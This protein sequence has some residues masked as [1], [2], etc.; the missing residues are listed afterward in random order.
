M[1]RL[2]LNR[3]LW[4]AVL[5]LIVSAIVF[6][7]VSLTPGSVAAEILGP[8]AATP[9]NVAALNAKLGLDQPFYVQY[10]MWLR[11]AVQGDLGTSLFTGEPVATMLNGRI[12]ATVSLMAVTT[13]VVAVIGVFLGVVS[14]LRKGGGGA[15]IDV[16]S[17]LAYSLPDF[18]MAL[19]LVATFSVGLGLL[20]SFG[21]TPF[22]EDPSQWAYFL[23]L[24]VAA[25][26]LNGVARIAKQARAA[27]TATLGR[28][29]VRVL[30]ANGFSRRSVIFKHA[31]RNAAI[32]IVSAIGL[33][34]TGLASGTVL[35]EKIF[36]I[37]GIGSAAVQA[38]TQHD[39][40]VVVGA[41]LYF[42][43]IVVVVNL[44]VDL[45]YGW[46]NPRARAFS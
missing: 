28:D 19:V 12:G 26:A 24:P 2:V 27:M 30:L 41:A 20:P 25:L 3:L 44:L 14:A 35:V 33:A 8:T 16:G 6:V 40:P 7:L 13:L 39:L 9:E 10:V 1:I 42:T 38:T 46:L 23:V 15:V 21:F 45:A 36:A 4:S 32:P 29:Y 34:F 43:V 37:P 5:L 22:A 17:L 31:L 18:W 11:H